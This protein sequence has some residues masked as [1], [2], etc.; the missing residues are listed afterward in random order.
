MRL[1][2][3]I[4]VLILLVP[5]RLYSQGKSNSILINFDSYKGTLFEENYVF[6]FSNKNDTNTYNVYSYLF[7]KSKKVDPW[8]P[9]KEEIIKI[10]AQIKKIIKK[11]YRNLDS[12]EYESYKYIIKNLKDYNRQFIGYIENGDKMLYINFYYKKIDN[13]KNKPD[14]IMQWALGGGVN[15]FDITINLSKNKTMDFIINAPM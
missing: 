1:E 10:D 9:Q 4:T 12:I 3:L 6:V 11:A 2:Y 5:I 8:T 7:G 14:S 13:D 15:F